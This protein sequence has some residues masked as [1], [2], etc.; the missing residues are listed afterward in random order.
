MMYSRVV[1]PRSSACITCH[2]RQP[3]RASFFRMDTIN[4]L[5][6]SDGPYEEGRYHEQHELGQV[7]PCEDRGKLGLNH[8]GRAHKAVPFVVAERSFVLGEHLGNSLA[9]AARGSERRGQLV[10]RFE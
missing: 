1:R 6:P 7:D 2:V 5:D 8:R 10:E 3:R 9:E 4:S